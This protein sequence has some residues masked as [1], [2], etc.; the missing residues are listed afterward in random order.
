VEEDWEEE[1]GGGDGLHLRN[2]V[3]MC[4]VTIGLFFLAGAE[5]LDIFD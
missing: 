4:C 3:A 2:L 1:G 5:M